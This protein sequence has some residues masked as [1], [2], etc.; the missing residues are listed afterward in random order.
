MSVDIDFHG[1]KYIQCIHK[2]G[3]KWTVH[4]LIQIKNFEN[5]IDTF[6]VGM[7]PSVCFLF[8]IR[9]HVL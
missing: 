5:K 3:L 1:Q 2:F 7:S 9:I 8:I 6:S 4:F